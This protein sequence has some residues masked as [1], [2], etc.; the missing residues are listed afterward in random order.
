[1]PVPNRPKAQQKYSEQYMGNTS[2]D[3]DFGVNT[4]EQLGYDGVALQRAIA[5]SMALKVTVSGTI[6]YI[7]VAAPGTAQS[8]AKWQCKKIDTTTGVVITWAD[9]NADFDNTSTDLTALTY[10]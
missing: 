2:F 4:V 8:T 6:T 1:M 10:S 7:G 3:E 9:G 5:D